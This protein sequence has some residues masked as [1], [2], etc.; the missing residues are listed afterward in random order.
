MFASS[1]QA[2][3]P[4]LYFAVVG[5]P[6]YFRGSSV[7][8]Y[9]MRL[10]SALLSAIFL[11][12]ALTAAVVYS[13]NRAMVVGL[14]VAATPMVFFLAGVVNPSG[15]E[16]SSAH[17]RM[18]DWCDS[19]HRTTERASPGPRRDVRRLSRDDGARPPALA[20]LARA[21]GRLPSRLQ[22]SGRPWSAR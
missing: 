15:L 20:T 5:L 3:Y 11:A 19:R 22:P 9:L 8:I 17:R 7:D 1:Y 14:V 21:L 4:P 18:D 2:R 13:T 6:S 16:I 10:V 12:L